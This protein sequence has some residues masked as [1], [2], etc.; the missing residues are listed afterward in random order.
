MMP[1][2]QTTIH[3]TQQQATPKITPKM[4]ENQQQITLGNR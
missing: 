2:K 3:G 1:L 4:S